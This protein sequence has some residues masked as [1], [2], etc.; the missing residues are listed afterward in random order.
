M[1]RKIISDTTIASI[2]VIFLIISFFI[3]SIVSN[4]EKIE[5]TGKVIMVGKPEKNDSKIINESVEV[6]KEID[7]NIRCWVKAGIKDE[8]IMIIGDLLRNIECPDIEKKQVKISRNESCINID[9]E[10]VDSD[11][12]FDGKPNLNINLETGGK[13]LAE[14]KPGV[15]TSY[16]NYLSYIIFILIYLFVMI[17]WREFEI[18]H[19]G[20]IEEEKEIIYIKPAPW[21]EEKISKSEKEKEIISDIKEFR[22]PIKEFMEMKE[23][24]ISK[25]IEEFN[26]IAEKVDNLIKMERINEAKKLY[27]RLL[28]IYSGLYNSITLDKIGR[29]QG[30]LS[31]LRDQ[32]RILSK[33]KKIAHMIEKAYQEIEH[34]KIKPIKTETKIDEK[35]L[36]HLKE[37]LKRDEYGKARKIVK[38]KERSY[39]ELGKELSNIRELIEKGKHGK[40]VERYRDLFT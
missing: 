11:L 18:R 39:K 29:M 30:V 32:I 24:E 23:E 15:I 2:L 5:K 9:S 13:G 37:L 1:I 40:A 16:D 31:Q 34:Y 20:K 17:I 6:K 38:V 4:T 22:L 28:R 14:E 26:E 21:Y 25:K 12:C 10:N 27:V 36:Q 7:K 8:D 33:S 35:R 3:I 19:P